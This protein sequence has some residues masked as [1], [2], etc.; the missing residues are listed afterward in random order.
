MKLQTLQLKNFGSYRDATI[1]LTEIAA[2]V[3]TGTNGAG[4]STGFVDAPLAALFGKCRVSLDDIMALG[5]DDMVLTLTFQLNGQ[6]YRVIRKRSKKTKAGKSEL[7]LQIAHGDSWEDAS[8]ARIQDTQDKICRLLNADYELITATG[9]LLQGQADRFSRATPT[10]RKAI[11]AQILRLDQYGPLKQAANRQVTIADAKHGEK[12][13][14]LT[15]LETE[16]GTLASLEARQ[17]EVAGALAESQKAIEQLEAHQQELMTKKARLAAELEQLAAIPEQISA[18]LTQQTTIRSSQLAMAGRRE[19]A[20]KILANRA[21]IEA[22]VQEEAALQHDFER[23]LIQED[24]LGQAIDQLMKDHALAIQRVNEGSTLQREVAEAVA[25]VARLVA[26]YRRETER[27]EQDV[28]RDDKTV[29]LLTQVPCGADLQS[30]CQFTL[31]AVKV[32]D[33]LPVKRKALGDRCAATLANALRI[34]PEA[35][36]AVDFLEARMKAWDEH[37]YQAEADRMAAHLTTLREDRTATRSRKETV[38]KELKA[39]T[40]YTTLVPELA[41]AEREGVQLDQD[42]VRIAGDLSSTAEQLQQLQSRQADREKVKASHD[43]VASSLQQDQ[44]YLAR[45]RADGQTAVGRLKEIELEIKQAQDAARQ[46]ELLRQ[47]CAQLLTDGRHF[48]ALATAYSQIPVL[49]LET[50]IPLLEEEA[51]RIL[52]KISTSGLRVTFNTQK[53]LKSRDGLA[54]TLDIAVRDVFGERMLENFS[55]GER[56]RVD[57]AVR[58]GLSKLLANRAGSRLETLIVDEA[59]AAVDRE[60]VEQ[61]VECLP[62]LTQ[63]FPV[64]LFIT[65]DENFKSSIAQQ[66]IVTKDHNG[67]KVEV[68]A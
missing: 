6:T 38:Q 48:Q 19:R 45:L 20:A 59:F 28:M 39:L 17:T 23:L 11:L 52:A 2:A 36:A 34:A 68:V 14:L 37:H 47:E 65:H 7:A 10:E 40:V 55:G 8:G 62:M 32:Q 29:G 58:I 22:K 33:A 21:T 27:L 57:L 61:L 25:H 35:V 18:L 30:T 4:K 3:V 44:Q 13:L 15:S 60:G 9:F 46:A 26:D 41:A 12:R 64:I 5:T 63:E 24:E 50:A 51:N 67:S 54:E 66:I 42:L 53:A 43:D 56:A 31:Q 49:I 1:D 16:A